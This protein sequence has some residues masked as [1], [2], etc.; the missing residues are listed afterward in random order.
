[1]HMTIEFHDAEDFAKFVTKQ[2]AFAEK[3]VMEAPEHHHYHSGYSTTFNYKALL[4]VDDAFFI[5]T[6]NMG[7]HFP[8]E[9]RHRGD[10]KLE[11]YF[12]SKS[13]V[14]RF[15]RQ[16]GVKDSEVAKINK[17]S[18]SS[19]REVIDSSPTKQGKDETFEEITHRLTR[20]G[21]SIQLSSKKYGKVFLRFDKDDRRNIHYSCE[22]DWT[23]ELKKLADSVTKALAKHKIRV[24]RGN[25]NLR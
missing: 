10:G 3:F 20:K 21:D 2:A 12:S 11:Q 8:P 13:D 1:M 16:I 15:L 22:A 14:V 4:K 23:K 6:L 7:R 19:L 25:V 17:V 18:V 9:W 5:A 24:V